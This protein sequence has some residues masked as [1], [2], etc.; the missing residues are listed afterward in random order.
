MARPRS[1]K[2]VAASLFDASTDPIYLLDENRKIVYANDALAG[3]LGLDREKTIGLRCDYHAAIDLGDENSTVA[4]LAPP[5]GEVAKVVRGEVAA[6]AANRIDIRHATFV[7]LMSKGSILGIIGIVGEPADEQV[8]AASK[9]AAHELLLRIRADHRSRYEVGRLVGV[10][11]PIQGA[12][13]RIQ[14]AAESSARVLVVGQKGSGCEHVART[15]H[16]LRH[17]EKSVVLTPLAGELLDADT[18]RSTLEAITNKGSDWVESDSALLL[19]DVDAMTGE[20]QSSLLQFLDS[21]VDVQILSTARQSL[22]T[23]AKQGRFREELA[24]RLSTVTIELPPLV[25]RREDISL[26]VQYAIEQLNAAGDKQISGAT[27]EAIDLLSAYSWPGNI[28]ELRQFVRE[29]YEKTASP[30]IDVSDLPKRIHL[31]ADASHFPF[32]KDEEIDL[33]EFLADVEAELITRAMKRADGN[34]AQAARLLKMNRARFLRRLEQVNKRQAADEGA[35][36]RTSE[37]PDQN[38]NK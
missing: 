1:P 21:E 34:R 33:D 29:A 3:W 15:I 32:E 23:L 7:P 37:N 5:P 20:T 22:D 17:Q 25:D 35:T 19:L 2:T 38:D 14:V 13:E 31:A 27:P 28:D 12:R 10:S 8:D 11:K 9:H 18:V 6:S 36:E 16:E 30:R 26:L 4:G 24:D